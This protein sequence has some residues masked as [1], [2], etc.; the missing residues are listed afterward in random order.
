VSC[1]ATRCQ[2][3][4]QHW[5]ALAAAVAQMFSAAAAIIARS[6][7][8]SAILF[9]CVFWP[10]EEYP[11]DVG[12][13]SDQRS[14]WAMLVVPR[15]STPLFSHHGSPQIRSVDLANLWQAS[16]QHR[17]FKPLGIQCNVLTQ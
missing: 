9:I 17:R 2:P 14:R 7:F 11:Y 3:N 13:M 5:P 10:I 8:V 15:P 4:G 16:D 1:E 12:D 6:L